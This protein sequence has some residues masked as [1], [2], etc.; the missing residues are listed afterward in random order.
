MEKGVTIWNNAPRKDVGCAKTGYNLRNA[1]GY[2]GENIVIKQP[3]CGCM[4][5]TIHLKIQFYFHI[6][7]YSVL[8]LVVRCG[9]IFEFHHEACMLRSSKELSMFIYSTA[10]FYFLLHLQFL[11][12]LLFSVENK[13]NQMFINNYS[14][15][16]KMNRMLKKE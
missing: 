8:S 5:E 10:V 11:Q 13:L 14:E 4:S 16:N 15:T 3:K 9:S 1:V 2:N 6:S 12:Q 7:T